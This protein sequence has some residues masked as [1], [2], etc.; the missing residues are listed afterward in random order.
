MN[1][2]KKTLLWSIFVVCVIMIIGIFATYAYFT[3]NFIGGNKNVLTNVD[4]GKLDIDFETSEY[5]DAKGYLISEDDYLDQAGST[6]FSVAKSSN[7]TVTHDV[8]FDISLTD[9][10]ITNNFKSAYLV[11]KLVED[12]ST[13][14]ASGNFSNIGSNTSIKLTN[15]SIL[16]D[17][18]KNYSVYVFLKNDVNVNQ[19]D[20]LNGTFAAK[21]VVD[22]YVH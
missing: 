2:D 4:T 17:E 3:R 22:S 1:K 6:K 5:I 18:I 7:S 14:V 19:L 21:V 20:L 16:L 8:Y 12:E 13:V 11:W 9:I 10:T 15:S